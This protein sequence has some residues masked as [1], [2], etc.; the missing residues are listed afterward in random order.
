VAIAR[1]HTLGSDGGAGHLYQN[2]MTAL[3]MLDRP[4]EARDAARNAYPRLLR[5]G[6][7]YRML[8]SLSLLNAM[9]GRPAAAARI[10]GFAGAIQTR[11]GENVSSLTP[12][13]HER[14]DPLLAA[15]PADARTRLAAEGAGLRDEEVFELA[16]DEAV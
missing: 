9:Q 8:L 14:L 10:A 6:D 11:L 13:I 7:A 4:N 3:L 2:E 16:F 1:L 15:L 5:E 12:L